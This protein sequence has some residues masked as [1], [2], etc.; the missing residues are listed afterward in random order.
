MKMNTNESKQFIKSNGSTSETT[1]AANL[2]E[3]STSD[4]TE[5]SM[6]KIE[7]KQADDKKKKKSKSSQRAKKINQSINLNYSSFMKS[8][9]KITDY[10]QIRKSSR[11]CKSDIEKEKREAIEHALKTMTEDGL[12]V[13]TIENKGR[14]VFATKRFERGEFICEYAG[15]MVSYKVAKKREEKYSADANIGCYMYFFEHKSKQYCVDATAETDRF[16]RLFNHSKLGGNCCTKIFEMNA[17]PFLIL[18]AARDIQAGEEL[19]YDYGDRN[20]SS[21]ESHPWLAQ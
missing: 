16:G 9:R 3:A 7:L 13:R 5:T 2:T 15:E 21:L 18:C 6:I 10:F 14:G 4:P 8:N 1:S 20:K 17:K 12:E 11:K 19:T